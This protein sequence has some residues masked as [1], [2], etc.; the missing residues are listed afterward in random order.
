MKKLL[1]LSSIATV[2]VACEP[3][4]ETSQT[5]TQT[6]THAYSSIVIDATSQTEFAYVD[7]DTSRE[8]TDADDWDIMVK[9]TAISGSDSAQIALANTP[10]SFYDADGAAIASSFVSADA[11]QEAMAL[12]TAYDLSTLSFLKD[13]MSYAIDSSWYI[14]NP[15]THAI[16]A[17]PES[18]YVVANSA[19]NE[20]AKIHATQ[21][22]AETSTYTFEV[23]SQLNDD[24][25]FSTTPSTFEVSFAGD[26][27]FNLSEAATVDCA[28]QN[29]DIRSIVDGYSINI[30]VSGSAYYQV[31]DQATANALTMASDLI[32][33]AELT[34]AQKMASLGY[35]FFADALKGAVSENSW[36][37]YGVAGGHELWPN[38]RT[39]VIDTDASDEASTNYAF[40]VANYYDEIDGTSAVITINFQEIK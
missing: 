9:R 34:E 26:V 10:E 27:C 14:Y 32:D 30:S 11:E 5:E 8:V 22:D 12:A 40:Q 39:Y 38:F 24:T 6:T 18:W 19:F 7:F 35:S 29:Y 21:Y 1:L 23:F 20:F 17:N 3:E 31:I 16:T 25:Q 36:Y 33:D 37:A 4:E 13:E 2:F 15:V 28:T